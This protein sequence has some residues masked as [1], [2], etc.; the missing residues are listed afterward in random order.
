MLTGF[1]YLYVFIFYFFIL[2]K[3]KNNRLRISQLAK[4][5]TTFFLFFLFLL[6]LGSGE[7]VDQQINFVLPQ[8]FPLRFIHDHSN[9]T[10]IHKSIFLTETSLVYLI[11]KCS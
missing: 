4:N 11:W 9:I 3:A 6:K 2:Q 1:L 10:I 5:V 8:I 7:L